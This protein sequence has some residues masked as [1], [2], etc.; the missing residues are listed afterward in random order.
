M[1]GQTETLIEN[2]STKLGGGSSQLF[3]ILKNRD[4]P[5]E[6]QNS[7]TKVGGGSAIYISEE[8]AVL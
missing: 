3:L 4:N 5:L 2:S 1:S 8:I 6:T 7:S